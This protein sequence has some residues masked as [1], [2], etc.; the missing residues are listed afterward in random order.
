VE[1]T[2][3]AKPG[4]G[5]FL[6]DP[7]H[8]G[9][10][11][12]V[13]L[14]DVSW[15]R[16]VDVHDV[17]LQGRASPVPVLRDVVVGENVL[18]DG[19]DVVLETN[20]ITHESRLIVLRPHDALDTGS[21]T[22]ASI[23]RRVTGTLS[24][25]LPKNDDGSATLPV[26]FVAR[27]ATVV[28][29]FDDLLEDGPEARAAL[30]ETVRLTSGYPPDTPQP[31]RIVFDPSHGGIA[32]GSFHSTRV[33]VDFTV[34]ERE[35]LELP[36]FVPISAA[37]LP[38]S[39]PFSPQ[40][41]T[42]VHLV[43][44]LD[45]PAGRFARLTN[46]AGR[47][48]EPGGPVEPSTQDVVR[49]FRTGN[50]SDANGGYLL[51]LALPSVVGTWD[52]TVDGARDD[53]L[54]P[55]GLG[56]VVDFTF[57][58][59]CRDAPRRGDTLELSGELY[60]VREQGGEPDSLGRVVNARILRLE[61]QPLG[62]PDALLGLARVLTPYRQD[63]TI[64]P[65]CWVAFVPPPL[66]PP[67]EGIDSDTRVVVRFSE[68]MDPSSFRAFDSFR[69]VR[70]TDEQVF[71]D[72]LVVGEVQGES[73]LQVFSFLP[74]LPLANQGTGQYRVELFEGAQG[75]RDLSGSGLVESF[76]RAGFQLAS[77]Q[78]PERNG[79]FALRFAERDELDP[80]GFPDVRGQVTYDE[81]GGILRPRRTVYVTYST[82]R[83]NPIQNLMLPW[84]LGVQTPLSP[85]GSKL[86]ALWRYCDFGWRVRDETRHDIDVI[87]LY[88]SPLGG[89]LVSDY[90]PRFEMRMAH[91]RYVP[92]ETQ[93]VSVGGPKYPQSGLEAGPFPFTNNL[94][95]DPRGPQVVVHPSPL[96]YRVRPG[97]VT[98]NSS[99][100]PLMPFPWN[101][102]GAP[103]TTYTWRDTTIRAKGGFNS[104]GVPLDIECGGPLGLDEGQ[105]E[106]GGN[107]EVPSIG[108]PLLW[109]IRC[110]PSS[111]GL[112]LNSFDI[113]LPILGFNLPNFRA[114]ST[115][116]I[117]QTGAQV[118]IDPDL[119]LA[120]RGGY[121]P[122]SVPPGMPTPLSADNSFYIGAIDTVVRVS[123]AVTIWIDTGNF[124]PR[125]VEP[126]IEPKLQIDGTSLLVEYRGAVS[127]TGA[128]NAP[129]D[130]GSLDP[131]GDFE[132]GTA[133]YHGDGSWSDD[134]HD[135][136][137]AR[138]LQLRF[139]FFNNIQG[140][141]SPELDAIGIAFE[142]G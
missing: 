111:A 44:Q 130:A 70:G 134:I 113:L 135:V 32:G 102:T 122:R 140:G 52:V 81:A 24:A 49:A 5:F 46:L 65:A 136:S 15:G 6:S 132:T 120:P 1:G 53:P 18:S 103:L 38:A 91:S 16:L 129:F 133:E 22:F 142:D 40:P 80:P 109:E 13:H 61:E 123:R 131:Y 62:A 27:N 117:D 30:L 25:V 58:T 116:G 74:R 96:G 97:D 45:P 34:S 115:G 93:V 14:V 112:G 141:L 8:G 59:P 90:Y 125:F 86:Q 64:H 42:S 92:D 78:R 35:A 7:H 33:L 63:S 56:F 31:A 128:G 100:T 84:P 51:D 73:N 11:S 48:L 39:S 138:F 127:F 26:S 108:L 68:P 71:G 60:E 19:T 37:G 2:L 88:W 106:V 72:D 67:F 114:F 75:V 43:T 77:G 50:G 20:A 85:L 9:G 17:D 139:S 124:A 41:N 55:A 104:P 47:P 99:G 10:A 12:R 87:G 89:A 95:E 126:A 76:R 3:V 101:R 110:F 54:G 79:G 121:N 105:G 66:A 29:R 119:E 69:L 83:A 118:L 21:G 94:L 82:D 137:G 107:G 98:V 23:V 57:R 4:G 36:V 28:L